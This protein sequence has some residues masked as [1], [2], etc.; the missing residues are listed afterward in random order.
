MLSLQN[1]VYVKAELKKNYKYN[2]KQLV[3][4]EKKKHQ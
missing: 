1:E 3:F 4:F 2:A